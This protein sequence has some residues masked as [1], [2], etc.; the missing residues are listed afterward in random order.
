ME[1]NFQQVH[2]LVGQ[3]GV[4]KTTILDALNLVR[5]TNFVASRIQ[6]QDF[7]NDDEDEAIE[8]E[9][10]YD[11]PFNVDV[12]DGYFN[13]Q[14]PSS[15]ISLRAKRRKQRGTNLLSDP[16]TAD[17][18]CKPILGDGLREPEDGKYELDRTRADS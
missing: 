13:R 3:N 18:F 6:E 1:M 7:N 9:V 16:F 4:G 2:A 11:S 5:T 15:T 8:I 14:I 17:H 10:E 12:V